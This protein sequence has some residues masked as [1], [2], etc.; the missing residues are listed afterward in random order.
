MHEIHCSAFRVTAEQHKG[1]RNRFTGFDDCDF[2]IRR[3]F[4][5]LW[6]KILKVGV[7]CEEVG[8]GKWE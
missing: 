4:S 1:R 2:Q 3:G 6:F 7:F 8:A 5:S